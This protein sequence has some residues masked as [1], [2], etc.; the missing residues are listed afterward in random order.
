MNII[1]PFSLFIGLRYTNLRKPDHFI[2]FISLV[3]IIGIALGVMVMITVMSVMNGFTKEIRTRILSV[4]PHLTVSAFTRE[5][6]DWKDLQLTIKSHSQY[7]A[8]TPFI[9]GQGM[10]IEGQQIIGVGI[11][12]ILPEKVEEVFPLHSAMI[13]GNAN[14]LIPGD[15]GIVLGVGL[16]NTLGAQVGDKLT[17]VIPDVTYTIAGATPRFKTVKVVG[18]FEVG[19]LYDQ[20]F[21]FLHMADAAKLFK[22]HQG[23][24]GLQVKLKDPFQSPSTVR[25]LNQS[26]SKKFVIIDWTMANGT[27]F[28]AVK[29]EKTMMFFTLLLILTIAVFNLVSTLVMVVTDKKGD[30]ALLRTLGASTR[31]IMAIFVVQGAVIGA[32]GTVLGVLLGA[33][34]SLNV[35]RI[36]DFIER[37]FQVQFL[38][39]DVYFISFL[40]SDL[41]QSD[42]ILISSC[43][44]GLSL[45]AT[46]WPAWRA[47]QIEP[48]KALRQDL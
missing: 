31:K 44:F 24:S 45:L 38:S 41:Q 43:A 7:V 16:A 26:L 37:L 29:T 11:R 42:V 20:N 23:V 6:T 33:A 40:P 8:S 21:A 4:T 34:L 25:D 10:F 5:L 19:Y 28:S 39:K 18:V 17:L 46:L 48:A 27:Y 32:I 12:G 2:S 9:D 35:T 30:I 15:F 22:M 47:A 1:K 3:S 13:A 14:Q 36:V